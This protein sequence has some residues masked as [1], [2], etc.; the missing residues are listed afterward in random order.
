MEV[1]DH[2]PEN[3]QI[4]TNLRL[5]LVLEEVARVGVPVTPTLVNA[6]LGLPKPTIHR[7]FATLE[8]EGF[9]QRELDGRSYTPG[10]RLRRLAVNVLSS[11]RVR[12]ARLAVLT[13]SR[14][15]SAR[16]ATSP[17]RTVM[18]WLKWTPK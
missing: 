8:A 15:T 16:P 9:L 17:S 5:L 6:A 2:E 4:P 11:L 7:L 14:T 3:G 13:R 18:P 1:T 10:P 12:T